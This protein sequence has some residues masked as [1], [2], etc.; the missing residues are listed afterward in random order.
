MH[1]KCQ[2]TKCKQIFYC[3]VF[4]LTHDIINNACYEKTMTSEIVE[5]IN[6]ETS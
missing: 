1:K 4:D 3:I 5:K 2:K 6:I